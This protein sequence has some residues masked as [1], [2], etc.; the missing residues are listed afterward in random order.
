MPQATA[1]HLV[2]RP[3]TAATPPKSVPTTTA[4]RT[5]MKPIRKPRHP[6]RRQTPDNVLRDL[7]RRRARSLARMA[8]TQHSRRIRDNL[9]RTDARQF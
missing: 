1:V 8:D 9:Q 6:V 3:E 2:S 5:V 4:M 7:L